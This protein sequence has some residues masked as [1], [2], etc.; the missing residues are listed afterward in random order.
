MAIAGL[1]LIVPSSVTATGGGSSVS[2]SASGKITATN[3]ATVS[4]NG[5]FSATYDNY[6]FVARWHFAGGDELQFRMRSSGSDASGSNYVRQLM[7]AASTT[8][9]GTRQSSQTEGRVMAHDGVGNGF[10]FYIWG[11]FLA[12]PTMSRAVG[13]RSG[14]PTIYDWISSHSLST[15]YDGITF[16]PASQ[17]I[18]GS[19][20]IYGL[21]Q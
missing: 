18:T 13:V 6:L 16:F 8:V 7:Q 5:C 2:V 14:G 19:M 11:P 12:E 17:T 9:S 10:H 3:C 21:S 1:K 15:S 20:T 4:I